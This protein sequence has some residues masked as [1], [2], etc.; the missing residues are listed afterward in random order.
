MSMLAS[1]VFLSSGTIYVVI[2]LSI[3]ASVS[4]ACL[5]GVRVW[6]AR[7]E[8]RRARNLLVRR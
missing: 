5:T 6:T 4:V 8:W 1:M 2:V 7:R 3:A